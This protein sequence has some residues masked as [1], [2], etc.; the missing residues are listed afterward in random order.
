M[1]KN[2]VLRVVVFVLIVMLALWLSAIARDN[3]AI[4]NMVSD[5]G[6]VGVFIAAVF[7]GFNLVVP[8]PVIAFLPL[9]VVSGLSQWITIALIILGVTIADMLAYYLARMGKHLSPS[10]LEN[11]TRGISM[12]LD[13]HRRLSL[14]SLFIFAAIIPLPNEILVLPMAFLGYR[15]LSLFIPVLLGNTVFNTLSML[16]VVNIFELLW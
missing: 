9:F 5:Y 10:S 1:S 4:Q 13:R 15:L 16:G 6:Y 11:K 7:S 2:T 12:F 3:L 8:V 14:V